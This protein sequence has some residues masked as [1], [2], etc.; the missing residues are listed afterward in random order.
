MLC[1]ECNS[2]SVYCLKLCTRCY[3]KLVR[4][5][6][7]DKR[8]NTCEVK[9]CNAPI[10]SH[11]LCDTHRKRVERHGDVN[12]GRPEGWG[13]LFL[14]RQREYAK[15]RAL[16]PEEKRKR[17]LRKHFKLTPEDYKAM[18]EAQNG[19]CAIC[20]QPETRKNA[21]GEIM[22]LAVDHNHTTKAVRQ[23][24]CSGHNAMLGLAGDD[25]AVLEAAAAYLRKHQA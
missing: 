5:R 4:R 8:T 19:A 25:P 6:R 23:L 9:D 15:L 2:M 1:V 18:L 21:K 14:R 12:A 3:A 7:K 13:N 17:H 20:G 24:L 16:P 22:T 10:V 11:N